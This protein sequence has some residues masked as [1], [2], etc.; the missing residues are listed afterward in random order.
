MPKKSKKKETIQLSK[1][2]KIVAVL[3]LFVGIICGVFTTY[4]Y[5]KNDTF[6][7]IGNIEIELNINDKYE[8]PGAKAIAFGKDISD[9]IIKT[10]EVDTSIAD[11]YV[12]K[13]TV[14]NFRF[15]NYTL[16]RKVTVKEV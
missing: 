5:T 12:I 15:K 8:D 13:Y 7:L 4:I 1:K 14:N 9:L 16:Y 11:D 6:E 3:L 2:T 10:G